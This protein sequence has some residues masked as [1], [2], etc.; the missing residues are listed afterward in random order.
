MVTVLQ[1][2]ERARL[3][4][5]ESAAIAAW[6]VTQGGAGK[7]LVVQGFAPTE[8][9]LSQAPS[10]T[11]LPA[12]CTTDAATG[13][14][15]LGVAVECRVRNPG[16]TAAAG[17]MLYPATADALALEALVLAALQ[18]ELDQAG[19]DRPDIQTGYAAGLD[20]ALVLVTLVLT[21]P[22]PG[23]IGAEYEL[24]PRPEPAP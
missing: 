23:L 15:R 19:L 3:A 20:P 10:V 8:A 2:I 22:V 13:K 17:A 5:G 24:N 21:Y 12:P 16:G 18:T 6:A 1:L 4:L 14:R 7:L 9:E 11:V